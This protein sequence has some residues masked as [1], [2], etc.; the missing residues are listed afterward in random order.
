MEAIDDGEE[1]THEHEHTHNHAHEEISADEEL[2]IREE[3]GAFSFKALHKAKDLVKNGAKL[4]DVAEAVEAYVRENGFDIAFPL[5]LSIDSEAAHYTPMLSD[6]K[7]FNGNVVKIDFGVG[8]KGILGD[9]ATTVD[10]SGNYQKLLDATEAALSDAISC[11]KAGVPVNQIGKSISEA[12]TSR[13]FLPI[14][15]LGGHGV[16]VHD[17]HSDPFIPNF[18]NG[19]TTKLEEGDVIAI[20]P[21]ATQKGRGMV[22]NGDVVEIYSVRYP[23]QTRSSV[24][25]LIMGRII[26]KEMV[27]PF[28]LRWFKDMVK[29]RFELHAAMRELEKAG[30]VEPHPMLVELGGGIVSQH[31]AEVE[32]E[33]GGC[34][35]LTK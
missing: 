2:K 31:E 34:K 21:F 24:S 35:V 19:D 27:E 9:C 7:I 12:I 10:L 26:E 30:A 14:K 4:I 33:K 15:N 8:K 11:V 23:A 1:T 17:L 28:A 22:G 18:D 5:N 6:E 32:V 25:R 13:G 16:R 20:E 3:V 29:S